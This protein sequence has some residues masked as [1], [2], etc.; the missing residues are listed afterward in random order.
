MSKSRNPV[1]DF[2]T[3]GQEKCPHCGLYFP[4]MRIDSHMTACHLNPE[5]QVDLEG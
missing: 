1:G 4:E 5:N 3:Q 2:Y